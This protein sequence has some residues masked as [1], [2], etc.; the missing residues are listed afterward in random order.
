MGVP[1]AYGPWYTESAEQVLLSDLQ[2][3]VNERFLYEYNFFDNWQLEIRLE[4][5][6]DLE[7]RR[8]YP[9]CIAGTRA[10]PPEDC[11]GAEQFNRLREHFSPFYIYHRILECY[12]MH[13]R[14]EQLTEEEQYEFEER[15]F[16]LSRFGYWS[17]IDK[18]D[19]RRANKRL[20]QYAAK[21]VSWR[22]FEEVT[23]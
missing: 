21:D 13:Q 14:R 4:K 2:L 7:A 18:F 19:R 3:R 20:K 8:S 1:R 9:L 23:W 15:Q 22:E 12:E 11:G 10:A 5:K 17:K 16:E 6:C